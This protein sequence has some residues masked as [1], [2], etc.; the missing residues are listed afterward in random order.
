MV[1]GPG[2]VSRSRVECCGCTRRKKIMNY[3]RR[4]ASKEL[5]EIIR[6][7]SIH[8]MLHYEKTWTVSCVPIE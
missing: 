8:R 4:K 3:S 7:T 6:T 5:V 2:S 1:K